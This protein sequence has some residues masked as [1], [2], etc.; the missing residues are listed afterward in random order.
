MLYHFTLLY[1]KNNTLLWNNKLEVKN[2]RIGN[3]RMKPAKISDFSPSGRKVKSITLHGKEN[4]G[5]IG[6]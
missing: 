1:F 4:S 5:I 3:K 6:V 2:E